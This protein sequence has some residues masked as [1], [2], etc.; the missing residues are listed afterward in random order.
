MNQ[1][2]EV[3]SIGTY[4][5]GGSGWKGVPQQTIQP[6]IGST[7]QFTSLASGMQGQITGT[8]VPGRITTLAAPDP[9][10]MR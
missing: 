4:R 2:T 5:R 9:H 1:D 3:K 10:M 7:R 8:D 6:T